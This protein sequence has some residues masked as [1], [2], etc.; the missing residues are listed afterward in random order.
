M[1]PFHDMHEFHY[2]FTDWWG[3]EYETEL[4]RWA[5]SLMIWDFEDL[6]PRFKIA[7]VL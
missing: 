3:C 7:D 2:E 1:N 5:P 4:N 6:L